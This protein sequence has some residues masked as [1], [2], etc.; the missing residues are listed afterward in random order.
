MQKVFLAGLSSSFFFLPGHTLLL[1]SLLR[2]WE[3]DPSGDPPS[4]PPPPPAHSVYS[5]PLCLLY[6]L[7]LTSGDHTEVGR[8]PAGRQNTGKCCPAHAT[9]NSFCQ[10]VLTV[11]AGFTHGLVGS[12]R[13]GHAFTQVA[14]FA[15]FSA[16]GVQA[17]G[18]CPLGTSK[19]HLG[20]RRSEGQSDRRRGGGIFQ[21]IKRLPLNTVYWNHLGWDELTREA[22]GGSKLAGRKAVG[23]Q[24]ALDCCWG[25]RSQPR[26]LTFCK[27]HLGVTAPHGALRIHHM[28]RA[29]WDRLPE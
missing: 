1:A 5:A 13:L 12:T 11:Q 14:G 3:G 7:L 20:G 6:H 25:V 17:C 15:A 10:L 21:G 26:W 29:A 16:M 24:C 18:T 19:G 2:G 28:G 27:V 4:G 23:G 8:G 9:P 22:L